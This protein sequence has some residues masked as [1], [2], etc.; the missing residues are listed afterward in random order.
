[1]NE[2]HVVTCMYSNVERT[3]DSCQYSGLC[4]SRVAG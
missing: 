3:G 4:S 1:M 2:V